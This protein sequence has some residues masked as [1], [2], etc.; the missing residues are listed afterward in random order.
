MIVIAAVAQGAPEAAR[1]TMSVKMTSATEGVVTL[2]AQVT[3]GWHIYGTNLPDGGPS[4]TVFDFSKST[5]VKFVGNLKPSVKPV[6]KFDKMF[7]LTLT[8]WDRPV[9][10]TRKFKVTKKGAAKINAS[11]TYM[12]CN[13]QSCLPPKTVT[14]SR[15]VK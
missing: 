2:K 7:E 12:G 15:D 8:W 11:V 5:G 6:S 9:T 13:D 1:W 10:F 14:F 3:P 4:S